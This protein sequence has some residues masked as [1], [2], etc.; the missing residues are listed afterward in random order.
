M[1]MNLMRD[2]ELTT[3]YITLTEKT[4]EP[5]VGGIKGMTTRSKSL[6][7]Q[8]QVID[9]P[10]ELLSLQKE[11]E[12]SLDGLRVNFQSFV[13][14][15]SIQTDCRRAIPTNCTGEDIR[16]KVVDDMFQVYY[17]CRFHIV[18]LH[19]DKQFEPAVDRWRVKQVPIG[20][21]N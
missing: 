11:V 18:K 13:T 20:K 19:C 6:P 14:S 2:N 16:M 4:F 15:I 8:S 12:M 9:I 1:R 5:D 3:E 7:M 17:K 10:R 21:A